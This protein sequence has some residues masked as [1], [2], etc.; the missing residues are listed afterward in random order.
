ML[1]PRPPAP[2]LACAASRRRE[3]HSRGARGGRRRTV[4]SAPAAPPR[5]ASDCP[6]VRGR[7]D[8]GASTGG[9][10]STAPASDAHPTGDSCRRGGMGSARSGR[11][12]GVFSPA[13]PRRPPRRRVMVLRG[14]VSAVAAAWR[15]CSRAGGTGIKVAV[16]GVRR[17]SAGTRPR[18]SS[19]VTHASS[20]A[21][22]GPPGPPRLLA[23]ARPPGPPRVGSRSPT[24]PTRTLSVPSSGCRPLHTHASIQPQP[25]ERTA[26]RCITAWSSLRIAG[27]PPRGRHVAARGGGAPIAPMTRPWAAA[28][29]RP[30]RAVPSP[31]QRPADGTPPTAD[32]VGVAVE[33][34]ARARIGPSPSPPPSLHRRAPQRVGV[35]RGRP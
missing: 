17:G 1:T 16:E 4:L 21:A 12:R 30:R 22:R 8:P 3:P 9:G 14:R 19:P 7:A 15:P 31:L 25:S 33:R 13:R 2:P 32:G 24:T 5:R 27:A 35:S 18:R 34:A 29:S 11:R 10:A 26:A 23:A 6:P 28:E 20:R